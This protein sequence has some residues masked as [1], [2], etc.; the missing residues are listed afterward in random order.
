MDV[1]RTK[2]DYMMVIASAGSD[3]LACAISMNIGVK[4]CARKLDHFNN[5]EIRVV[6]GDNVRNKHMIVVAQCRT[7]SV[8]DDIM[9]L[10]MLLDAL[11]RSNAGKITLILP[12]YPYS[13]S[14]KRD[15][16]QR[17]PIGT[18]VIAGMLEWSSVDTI[19]CMDL[20][21]GQTQSLIRRGFHN[22]YF[23]SILSNYINDKYLGLDRG[24]LPDML[25]LEDTPYV[26]VAPDEGSV[27]TI[28]A[29]SERLKIRYAV[30]SK[31]RNYLQP[32]TV[33]YSQIIGG[34]HLEGKT[35]IIVDDMADSMGTI[36][37]AVETLKYVGVKSVIIAVTHGIFSKDAIAKINKCEMISEIICSDSLPQEENVKRCNKLHV[38]SCV[39]LIA[40]TIKTM[41]NSGS[42]LALNM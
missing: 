35:A 19:M 3:E 33:S 36:I 4:I 37:S 6:I 11:V 21:S 12:Y 18:A 42:V 24:L 17:T 16:L 39:P 9:A 14:D 8:N 23:I 1:N 29:Y 30:L 32:G 28:I 2:A 25:S 15:N 27:K 7:N 22:L 31:H 10:M 34:S 38:L 5:G 41:E 13:R 26:L 40:H 20:H